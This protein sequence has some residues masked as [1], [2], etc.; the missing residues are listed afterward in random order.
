MCHNANYDL[1]AFE[2][3]F[4]HHM[5]KTFDVPTDE[6]A[7]VL[8]P[9]F[10]V[11]LGMPKISQNELRKLTIP[12]KNQ[13]YFKNSFLIQAL[14]LLTGKGEMTAAQEDHI[15]NLLRVKRGK[16]HSGIISCTIFTSAYP[17]YI[18]PET[19]EL[20]KQMFSCAYLCS[21]CPNSADMPKSYL[22]QEPGVM[23]AIR[24]NFDA[25]G[26]MWG[27][28]ETL[29]HLGHKIDKIEVIILGGTVSNYP[30]PYREQFARDTYYAANVF[31]DKEQR[32]RKSLKEEMNINKC[33]RCRIIGITMETRPDK[34]NKH[35]IIR[36]RSYGCTRIQLGV[37]HLDNDVLKANNRQCTTERYIKALQ[38]LKNCAFKVDIHIMFNLHGSSPEKDRTMLLNRFFGGNVPTNICQ[39][40]ETS[41]ET[42]DIAE[43]DISM[44]YVKLYPCEVTPYTDLEKW[45]N[46]GK[47]VPYPVE[48]VINILYETKRV[49]YPWVRTARIGRDIPMG[50]R[51]CSSDPPNV[52][53]IVLAMLEKNGHRCKCIRCRQCNEKA[54]DGTYQLIVRQYEASGG[55]EYFIS[56]ESQDKSTLYGFTRLRLCQPAIE[57][58]PELEG[59]ALIREL[60]VYS[61]MNPVGENLKT[62]QHQGI[63]KKLIATAETIA[64]ENKYDK[65]A[66]IAG[67]GV[68]G[69]YAKIG[70]FNDSEGKGDFMIKHF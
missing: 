38:L 15:L 45:Y 7:V 2:A 25:C 58:F 69:F 11:L 68:Q 3:K 52:G 56:A 31:G 6:D 26:Q 62:V 54:W 5:A 37:Q 10:E 12:Y 47:Y 46:E 13:K 29:Y 20:K 42:Y 61:N 9:L 35:E 8:K 30:I 53:Q 50:Y 16:S 33:A 66:I 57:V 36:L 1:E 24:Y 43:S 17:E 34:I 18:D 40:G 59:C 21:F 4:D 67:I 64:Q 41:W 70:Y 27:R 60:H 49:M 55:L 32:E 44:D 51:I 19:G 63:G 22:R 23:R 65:M 39:K 28:L 14:Y 48:E